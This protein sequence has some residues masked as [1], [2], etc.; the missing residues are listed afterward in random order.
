MRYC[1]HK[2]HFGSNW[3]FMSRT[4]LEKKDKVIKIKA[5]LH[6]V[7]MLYPCKSG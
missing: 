3:Q 4:D 6:H 2:S 1:A 5:A 7:P